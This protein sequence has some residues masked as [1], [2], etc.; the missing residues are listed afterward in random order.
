MKRAKEVCQ[1]VVMGV[2]AFCAKKVAGLDNLV[3][4]ILL[5]VIA[6]GLCIIFR[7]AITNFINTLMGKLTIEADKLF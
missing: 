2:K 7:D 4:A 1:E 5:C 3:V 6:L